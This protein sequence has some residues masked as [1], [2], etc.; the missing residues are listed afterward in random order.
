[1]NW[2]KEYSKMHTVK[3]LGRGEQYTDDCSKRTYIVN[4]KQIWAVV[5]S[6]G[7]VVSSV[8]DFEQKIMLDIYNQ[9]STA[10]KI[11]DW[12]NEHPQQAADRRAQA[13]SRFKEIV[14]TLKAKYTKKG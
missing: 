2:K 4:C 6:Q 10:Q 7:Q 1:M 14:A 12:L 13:S 8:S 5:N 11:A 9:K 3:K